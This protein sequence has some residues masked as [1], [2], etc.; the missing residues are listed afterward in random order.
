MKTFVAT[1]VVTIEDDNTSVS[2]VVEFLNEALVVDL[3]IENAGNSVQAVSAEVLVNGLVEI[4][5]H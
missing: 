2:D 3:D 4:S 1:F 5:Q